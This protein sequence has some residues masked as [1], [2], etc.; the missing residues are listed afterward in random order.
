MCGPVR[1]ASVS[2]EG[3]RLKLHRI[4][5]YLCTASC[6]VCPYPGHLG[7]PLAMKKTSGTYVMVTWKAHSQNIPTHPQSAAIPLQLIASMS[8]PYPRAILSTSP[9]SKSVDKHG[10]DVAT[11]QA[12]AVRP[13]LNVHVSSSKKEHQSLVS[14]ACLQYNSDCPRPHPYNDQP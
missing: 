1:T 4:Y 2:Y 9:H 8:S 11:N 12:K 3:W 6:Q 5:I 14:E 13:S 7:H 10:E